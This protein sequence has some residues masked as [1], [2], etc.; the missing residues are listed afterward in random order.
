MTK[1]I[2]RALLGIPGLFIMTT[3]LVFLTNPAAAADKLQ[4]VAN[5]AEGLSNLRGMLGA[6]L[7]AIGST[8]VLGAITA[9][10][11]YARPAAIFLLALIGA[12]LASYGLDGA[13]QPI[14]LFLTV[15]SVTFGLML[16]G[17]KL[18][19]VV[20]DRPADLVGGHGST[21]SS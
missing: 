6:P 18:L 2:A 4:L 14:L 17:H 12:R 11:E 1:N 9:R 16:A 5:G 13:N 7:F 20:A 8:L 21:R 3:G 15:P 19:D 10:L